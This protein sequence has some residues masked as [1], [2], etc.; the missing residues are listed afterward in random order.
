M[1][2]KRKSFEVEKRS[3]GKRKSKGP[4]GTELCRAGQAG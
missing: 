2:K 1:N 3:S 4:R